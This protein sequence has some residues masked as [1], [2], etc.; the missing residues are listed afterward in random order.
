MNT[1]LRV[2]LV[3][4]DFRRPMVHRVFAQEP[5]TGLSTLLVREAKLAAAREG[6]TLRAVVTRAL[7]A[8]LAQTGAAPAWRLVYGGLKHLHQER[9]A[10]ERAVEDEFEKI[11]PN[12]W[13]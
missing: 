7:E 11:D 13:E 12:A 3:D 10:V 2:L 5:G 6:T 4:A 8:E 9:E 1:Q